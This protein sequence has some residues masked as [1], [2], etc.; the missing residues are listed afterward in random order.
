MDN[1]PYFKQTIKPLT[2]KE[3]ESCQRT[4]IVDEVTFITD[5]IVDTYLFERR[6]NDYE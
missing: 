6:M 4:E 5:V 2:Y 1:E 3:L